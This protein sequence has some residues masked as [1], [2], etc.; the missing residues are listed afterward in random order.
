[1]KKFVIDKYKLFD[2]QFENVFCDAIKHGDTLKV[3]VEQSSHY[4]SNRELRR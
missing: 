1:M 2:W 4:K 3:A